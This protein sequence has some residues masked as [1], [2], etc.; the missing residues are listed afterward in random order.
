MFIIVVSIIGF[1]DWR[2]ENRDYDKE[3]IRAQNLKAK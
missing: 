1:V 2:G 3:Y